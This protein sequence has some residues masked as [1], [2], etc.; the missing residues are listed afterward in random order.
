MKRTGLKKYEYADV[1]HFTSKP[2]LRI[3]KI[4]NKSWHIFLKLGTTRK[5]H[6]VDYPQLQKG[7]NYIFA[8]NH[9][10][11]ED[12]ISTLY[13][14]DR[15]AYVLNGSTDQT[16]H[17]PNFFAL[18]ANGM[19]Y[20]NRCDS[21]SRRQAVQKMKRVLNAGNSI[22][23]FPEGGYNN[24]EEKLINRLFAGPWLLA[25]E[26][27]TEVVP[28]ISFNDYG[29]KDIYISAGSPI[30]LDLYEKEE[31][32]TLLRDAMATILWKLI[33]DY[34][35]P[36]KRMDIPGDLHTFW[37]EVRKQVYECQDWYNDVWEEELTT[38]KGKIPS[39]EEVN[40]FVDKVQINAANAWVLA[41]RLVQRQRE[42]PCDLIAFLKK[43]V[44]LK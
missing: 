3:R 19:I 5:I 18:W 28:I 11:D 20:V 37:M 41:P 10:F 36:L 8:C 23:L 39:P 30:Q 24:T 40:K 14:I 15:N 43:N 33:E 29:S 2:G 25:K 44:M 34:A 6:I 31:A 12:V 32:R 17:N 35:V 16:E 4:M 9:S 38:Y 1:E 42:Q 7:K 13:A 22:M 27:G 21:E 26:C